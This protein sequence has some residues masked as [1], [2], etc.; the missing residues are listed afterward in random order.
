MAKGIVWT[1]LAKADIRGIEQPVALQILRTLARYAKTEIGNVKQ[2]RDVEPP[3]ARLRA[4]NH[5]VFFR[6]QG[7]YFEVVRVLDRKEAY[8]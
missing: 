8:R 3:L 4:Q 2:L 6:D 1:E 7:E 5:R